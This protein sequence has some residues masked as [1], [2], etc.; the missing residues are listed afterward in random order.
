MK[1]RSSA[2]PLIVLVAVASVV[3]QDQAGKAPST[4]ELNDTEPQVRLKAS[5]TVDTQAN[6][7]QEF[8]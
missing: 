5:G 3:G 1:L 7:C 2:T 4:E 8:R 6:L